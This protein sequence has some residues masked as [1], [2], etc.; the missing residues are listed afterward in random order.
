M[1]LP[2]EH[3]AGT[4]TIDSQFFEKS[5]AVPLVVGG[6]GREPFYLPTHIKGVANILGFG[7]IG[8]GKSAALGAM[9]AAATGIP[10]ARVVW[11]DLGYSSFVLAHAM[12]ARYIEL[13]ADNSSPLCPL[14]HLDEVDGIGWIF[15][16]LTRLF[17]RWQ[18]QLNEKQATDL[19]RAIELAKTQK[20]RTLTLLSHLIQDTRL[21]EVLKNYCANGKWGHVFDGTPAV[22][23]QAPLTVYEMRGLNALGDRCIAP[24]TE[25]ILRGIE[26]G[27]GQAPTFIYADEIWKLLSDDVSREWFREAIRTFRRGNAGFIG[28]TQS[29]TEV[30]DSDFCALLLESFPAK[31]F[32]P[33]HEAKGAYV[34]R[35]Y[36]NLG[37]PERVIDIIASAT[38]K[39]E[40]VYVSDAGVRKASLDLGPIAKALCASTGAPDVAQARGV[41]AKYGKENFRQGWLFVRG[42]G[43]EPFSVE[44]SP[45]GASA[46][47]A[48]EQL[49]YTNGRATHA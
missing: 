11:L 14:Q 32:F 45:D 49:T 15:D 23:S 46:D 24:A 25:L 47:R 26:V 2:V 5:T 27:L 33:N 43:P 29:L 10:G 20:L 9:V 31:V 19:T 8:T 7:P 40:L 1:I 6:T 34:R 12:G 30:A 16:W 42:L 17:T 21:R 41:L 28:M 3:W 38:P 4:Q 22:I 37:I 39:K 13:A 44:P 48:I 18:I 36:Q 35:L